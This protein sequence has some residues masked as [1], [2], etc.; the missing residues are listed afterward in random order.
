MYWC[1]FYNII[2]KVVNLFHI[3]IYYKYDLITSIFIRVGESKPPTVY[4]GVNDFNAPYLYIEY[5][6][7]KARL[8]I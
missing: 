4:L 8:L 7:I 5:G 1:L 2:N 3:V 6:R